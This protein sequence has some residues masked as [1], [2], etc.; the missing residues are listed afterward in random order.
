METHSTILAWEI[1]WTEESGGLQSKG[2]K[3]L[4]ITEHACMHSRSYDPNLFV[5]I[6]LSTT[7]HSNYQ[8]IQICYEKVMKD[9]IVTCSCVHCDGCHFNFYFKEIQPVLAEHGL[10]RSLWSSWFP[11]FLCL[12]SSRI[13]FICCPP[14]ERVAPGLVKKKVLVVSMLLIFL[15]AIYLGFV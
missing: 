13:H 4:D 11:E 12:S 7:W 9:E 1:L 5:Y 2:C 6:Q 10:Y 8:K 14:F 3:E 15:L